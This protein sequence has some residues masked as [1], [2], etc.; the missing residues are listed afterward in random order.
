MC[1]LYV[2]PSSAQCM[3]VTKTRLWFRLSDKSSFL[4]RSSWEKETP[5]HSSSRPKRSSASVVW[6][7]GAKTG[8][9]IFSRATVWGKNK[10]RVL[11]RI[12]EWLIIGAKKQAH[13]CFVPPATQMKS[14]IKQCISLRALLVPV[15]NLK[16]LLPQAPWSIPLKPTTLL[17]P[18]S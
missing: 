4:I 9:K 2:V 13:L 16:L 5:S 10:I 11:Q 17:D 15:S 3:C 1:F 12:S 8:A 18:S 14:R 7:Q 6:V